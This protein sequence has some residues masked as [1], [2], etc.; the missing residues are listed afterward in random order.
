MLPLV[1]APAISA[2]L[3]VF[4]LSA[5][6]YVTPQF[7]GGTEGVM[8]GVHI[9]AAFVATGDWALGAALSFLMLIAFVAVYLLTASACASCGST[10]SGSRADH[11]RPPAQPDH[12]HDHDLALLFL[13]VPLVRRGPVLVP[14]D[15]QPV[16]P[17]RGLLA[18][19][20]PATCSAP[21]VSRGG[22]ATASSLRPRRAP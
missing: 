13:Y 7:L 17:V 3:F 18:A 14:L 5:A 11:G 20:V 1:A 15:R 9:Q 10:G 22:A 19:L 21:R 6:D 4:V 12:D 16:V 2:F 8:L